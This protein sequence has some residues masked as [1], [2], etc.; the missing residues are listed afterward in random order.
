MWI[1]ILPPGRGSA[2]HTGLSQLCGPHHAARCFASVNMENTSARG[3]ANTRVT[4]ISRSAIGLFEEF[5][6]H[7]LSLP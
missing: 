3:A 1:R 5:I 7:V 6:T 4:V 2:S